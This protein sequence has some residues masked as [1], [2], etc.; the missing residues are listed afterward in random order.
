MG[1]DWEGF[2]DTY[3][4]WHG[5][6]FDDTKEWI[7]YLYEKHGQFVGPVA[8]E[9]G[10]GWGTMNTYLEKCGLLVRKKQGG[11]NYINRPMGKKE[12][13]FVSIP[14]KTMKELSTIQISVRCGISKW[15]CLTL[16]RRHKREYVRWSRRGV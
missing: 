7:A 2:K 15:Y 10:I 9:L 1:V 12:A 14:I 3:N 6:E 11:N 16:L 4:L 8:R 5:T 13:L